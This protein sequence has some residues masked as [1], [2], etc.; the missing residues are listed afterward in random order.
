MKGKKRLLATLTSLAMLIGCIAL[1]V[2]A[3]SSD[4][5]TTWEEL[6]DAIADTSVDYVKLGAD[7]TTEGVIEI[8]SGRDFEIQMEGHTL[9]REIYSQSASGQVIHVASGGKL[10][11]VGFQLASGSGRGTITGG[12]AVDGGGIKNEGQLVISYVDI[13]NNNAGDTAA[14]DSS[15]GGGIWNSGA[16]SLSVCSISGNKSDDGG[17]IFNA[18]SGTIDLDDVTVSENT[19]LLHGGGGITNYGSITFLSENTI[20]GNTSKSNG[21][22]VWNNGG[23]IIDRPNNKLVIKDNDSTAYFNDNLYLYKDTLIT[24][25]TNAELISGTEI[26]VSVEKAPR[27]ITYNWNAGENQDMVMAE[28]NME[29]GFSN[30]EL[31]SKATYVKREWVDNKIKET[32]LPIPDDAFR[33]SSFQ[34]MLDHTSNGAV[35]FQDC[36]LYVDAN[37]DWQVFLSVT[38]TVNLVIKDDV[39]FQTN[40]GIEVLDGS[41][42]NI[43]GQKAD[44]GT[45][46]AKAENEDDPGRAGIGGK[47]DNSNGNIV[48]HGGT[49]TAAGATEGAGIGTGDEAG[50]NGGSIV[51]YGG[52]ITA[53]GGKLAAGIGGGDGSSGGPIT[54]YGGTVTANAGE[55]GAGIG[56]GEDTNSNNITI[57]GGTITANGGRNTVMEGGAG[58]GSG[59]AGEN[60]ATIKIYGGEIHANGGDGAPG[61]GCGS[62]ASIVRKSTDTGTIE[63]HGGSV[64]AYGGCTGA[65][66]GGGDSSNSNQTILIKGGYVE[67]CAAKAQDQVTSSDGAAGIGAGCGG[68]LSG[69]FEGSITITGGTVKAYASGWN[70]DSYAKHPLGAAGIGGGYKGHLIGSVTISGGDVEAVGRAGGAGI[71]GGSECEQKGSVEIKGTAKVKVTVEDTEYAN[72]YSHKVQMIGYGEVQNGKH[73]EQGPLTLGG[74]M[75]VWFE[76]HDVVTAD[77]RIETCRTND[78]AYYWLYIEPCTHQGHTYNTTKTTHLERCSHCATSFPTEAHNFDQTGKCTVCGYQRIV[79]SFKGHTVLLSDRIGLNF[80]VDLSGLTSEERNSSYMTFRIT[81]RGEVTDQDD[82]DAGYTRTYEGKVCYGFTAEINAIQMA[83]TITATFNYQQDGEWKTVVDTYSVKQYCDKFMTDWNNRVNN[84]EQHS[85]EDTKAKPVI[86][87][88]ADYGHYLQLYLKSFRGWNFDPETGYTEMVSSYNTVYSASELSRAYTETNSKKIRLNNDPNSDIKAVTYSLN[89]DSETCINVYFEM[90]EGKDYAGRFSVSSLGNTQFWYTTPGH[91]GELPT[92]ETASLERLSDGR[93]RLK[94]KG[95]LAQNLDRDFTFVVSTD[96]TDPESFTAMVTV[97]A[98]S[99]VN[100]LAAD[101]RPEESKN[102]AAAF[103]RYYEATR[104]F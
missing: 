102:A 89:F 41:T 90:N 1:P 25:S 63:I 60:C 68:S 57:Y 59:E 77:K 84:N 43:Y 104:D 98:L 82:V 99:Y 14:A 92:G 20:T 11:I 46:I 79:P 3:D 67:A 69:D 17:G 40:K 88:L 21:G 48:I 76:N 74:N 94:I 7:I 61:I 45:I 12:F 50:A 13:I 70:F 31:T 29:L 103:Y 5:V 24:L 22:G 16:L 53:T 97:S 62:G 26:Y 91:P 33:T 85:A 55:Q 75:M 71:G 35:R 8:S 37:T 51:I 87:A 39:T 93:Y 81:G 54:I 36:W 4:V 30:G 38:G 83:D 64:Y 58:I 95:I 15:H 23:F 49:I 80:F 2:S 34:Q 96:A 52:T 19:S 56:S 9:R 72:D 100:A 42:L 44:S 28:G 47:E 101:G 65:G 86:E 73:P 27:R 32:S 6:K 66:I 78:R 10:N 18:E